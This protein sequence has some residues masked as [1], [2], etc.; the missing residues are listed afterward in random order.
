VFFEFFPPA[1]TGIE[2]TV[3][4]MGYGFGLGGGDGASSSGIRKQ[5]S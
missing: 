1:P 3:D 5:Q 2:D 4:W